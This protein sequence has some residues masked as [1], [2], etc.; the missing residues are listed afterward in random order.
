MTTTRSAFRSSHES[1]HGGNRVGRFASQHPGMVRL[2]RGGWAAKGAVYV[3]AGLLALVIAVRASSWSDDVGATSV[4]GGSD[5]ASP[6]GAIERIAESSGGGALLW[7]LALG[8]FLYAAWRIVSAF[9]P[10]EDDAMSWAK[11]IGYLVSAVLYGSLGI[12]AV[13]F[14]QGTS[15]S[16]DGNSQVSDLTARVMENTGG[17]WLIG[18]VGVITIAVGIYRLGKGLKQ[19]VADE[20]DLS[21]MSPQRVTWSRRLGAVGEVGRGIAMGLIGFFLARAAVNY[22][23][24]EA[25]GLDGALR[26]LADDTWGLVVV[27]IV[28][29]GFVAYGAFCLATFTHRR[30]EAA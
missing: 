18:L 24:N 9:L 7:L 17:R 10:G 21:G 28:G 12:T 27:A 1:S 5:E 2:A 26:R 8:M 20:L 13:R 23:A 19:D 16:S 4:G 11:R 22:D 14:A 15:S 6:T 3:V 25:T 30:L 29:I